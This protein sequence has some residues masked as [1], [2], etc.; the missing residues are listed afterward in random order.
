MNCAK[1]AGSC[2]VNNRLSHNYSAFQLILRYLN[3]SLL[4]WQLFLCCSV[5]S[6]LECL[7]VV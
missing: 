2:F 7:S 3:E 4:P 1:K 5:A 6:R